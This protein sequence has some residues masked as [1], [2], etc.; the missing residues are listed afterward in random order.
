MKLSKN[1]AWIVNLVISAALNFVIRIKNDQVRIIVSSLLLSANSVVQAL[2]DSDADDNAQMVQILNDIIVDSQMSILLK[3]LLERKFSEI[4][5]PYDDI[6]ITMLEL[7]FD[8]GDLLTDDNPD[9]K[10]QANE[11]FKEFF[12]GPNGLM[13]I[14][15]LVQITSLD[16]MTSGIIAATLADFIARQF[17]GDKRFDAFLSKVSVSTKSQIG[18]PLQSFKTGE[19]LPGLPFRKA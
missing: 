10:G 4:E 19:K 13:F 14:T 9:N 12:S 16:E 7:V 11:K 8:T 15:K 1:L 18:I 3:S 17:P 2:S 5:D 6:L